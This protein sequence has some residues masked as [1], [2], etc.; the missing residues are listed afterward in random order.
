M[1]NESLEPVRRG[2]GEGRE[3]RKNFLQEYGRACLTFRMLSI[4]LLFQVMGEC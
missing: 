2:C 1:G 4:N 3:P